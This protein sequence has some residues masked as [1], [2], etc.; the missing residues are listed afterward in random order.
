MEKEIIK[1]VYTQEDMI[2]A[3]WYGYQYHQSTQFPKLEFEE[4]CRNNFLQWLSN[5]KSLKS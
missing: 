1:Q 2:N 4:N 5:Y 3:A